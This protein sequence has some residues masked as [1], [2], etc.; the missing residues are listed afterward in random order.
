MCECPFCGR[1]HH[2]LA[3]PPWKISHDDV[4]ALSRAFNGVANLGVAQDQRINEWLK[5]LITISALDS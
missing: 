5:K 3:N 1:L 4:C 2:K